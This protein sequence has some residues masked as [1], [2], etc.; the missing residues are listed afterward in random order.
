MQKDWK[1]GE[2]IQYNRDLPGVR[3]DTECG[4]A[5]N[6]MR[7]EENKTSIFFKQAPLLA[8]KLLNHITLFE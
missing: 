1:S 8:H 2:L 6:S 4:K 7:F 3:R 5:K